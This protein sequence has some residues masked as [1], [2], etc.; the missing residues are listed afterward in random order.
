MLYDS[1]FAPVLV[2]E[3]EPLMLKQL[4]EVVQA[5][6][7]FDV[8]RALNFK[9]GLAALEGGDIAALITDIALPDGDGRKLAAEALKLNGEM[10]LILISGFPVS[11]LLLP[12]E[13][14]RRAHL[15]EKPFGIA[16]LR[17]LLDG[18]QQEFETVKMARFR[19]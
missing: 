2:V 6:G 5:C 4:A 12:P 7:Y 3:D 11:S 8:R 1:Y 13:L 19:P 14:R 17:G 15:L 18:M 9:D 16:D 10:T